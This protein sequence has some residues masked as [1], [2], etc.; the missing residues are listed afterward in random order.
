MIVNSKVHIRK[1]FLAKRHST[2]SR[3][4]FIPN[5]AY[6]YLK[7]VHMGAEKRIDW[8]IKPCI[9]LRYSSSRCCLR[10]DGRLFTEEL[11]PRRL[12]DSIGKRSQDSRNVR[13]KGAVSRLRL[14]GSS[15]KKC[16]NY[17]RVIYL[18]CGYH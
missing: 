6:S 15:L 7:R 11:S 5:S 17:G 13:G 14:Q 4:D 10:K 1:S 2:L 8:W 9:S 18:P 3:R 16:V 12:N